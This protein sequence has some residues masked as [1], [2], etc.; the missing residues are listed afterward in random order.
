MAHHGL[1]RTNVKPRAKEL[2]AKR[3]SEFVQKPVFAFSRLFLAAI[4]LAAIQANCY[5]LLLKRPEHVTI[6]LAMFAED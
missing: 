2:G 5:D 6:R 1:Y 4:T 3:R